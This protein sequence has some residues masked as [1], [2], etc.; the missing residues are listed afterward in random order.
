MLFYKV[1]KKIIALLFFV[2][3]FV[4][5]QNFN[6][7]SVEAGGGM[8]APLRGYDKSFKSNFSGLRHFDVGLRYMFNEK[9]GVKAS[10]NY[11]KFVNDPGG[12]IGTEQFGATVQAYYNL[13]SLIYGIDRG[14]GENFSILLHAG[15]GGTYAKPINAFATERI[16][17]MLGGFTPQVKI[18]E[19]L[20]IYSDFSLH[21]D[22][23]QNYRYDGGLA[24]PTF[25]YQKGMYYTISFGLTFYLGRESYH[26]DWY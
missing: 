11:Q 7:L 1:M 4:G 9:F 23:M 17:H 8:V 13:R 22:L 24:S 20:A 12:V 16:F 2:F 21:L 26:A 18:S 5:A 25:A 3:S 14:I 10:G 6:Q 19:R 15:L